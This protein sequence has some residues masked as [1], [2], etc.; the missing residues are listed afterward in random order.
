MRTNRCNR[1]SSKL[2]APE[3][4]TEQQQLSFALLERTRTALAAGEVDQAD[5]PLRAAGL[6]RRREVSAVYP[7]D[8]LLRE[9]EGWVDLE[10]TI[11]AEGIP[12][13][14]VVKAAE[15]ART[16]NIAAVT[17]LRQWRFEPVARNGSPRA[18]RATLRM[19]FMLKD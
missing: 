3:V 2:D 17:A 7:R 13:D 14:V 12:D 8:A 5:V 6:A 1:L 9:V 16:F 10:F 4:R 19:E 18:Q 11:S 15:P